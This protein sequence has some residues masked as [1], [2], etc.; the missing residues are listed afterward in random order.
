MGNVILASRGPIT[1]VRGIAC[2]RER[3]SLSA[4]ANAVPGNPRVPGVALEVR[5]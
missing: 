2:E 4:F 3:G 5:W 1:L